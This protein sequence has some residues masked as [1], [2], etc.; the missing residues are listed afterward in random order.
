MTPFPNIHDVTSATFT[1]RKI[2]KLF[3]TM[4]KERKIFTSYS[5]TPILGVGNLFS[6]RPTTINNW[7]SKFLLLHED[8]LLFV[9][10][11]KKSWP[12]T[13]STSY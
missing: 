12:S 13:S 1:S 6:M 2:I 4:E 11:L 8:V 10:F 7:F 9:G 5:S 3:A